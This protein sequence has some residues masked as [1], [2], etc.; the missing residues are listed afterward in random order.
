MRLTITYAA[1][2]GT[3][4]LSST[5]KNA[6]ESFRRRSIPATWIHTPPGG[7]APRSIGRYPWLEATSHPGT[8]PSRTI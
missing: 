3:R 6:P 2:D 8:T 4:R 5:T 7:R 1:P